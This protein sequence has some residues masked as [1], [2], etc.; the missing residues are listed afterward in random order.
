MMPCTMCL[1]KER[2]PA[3]QLRKARQKMQRDDMQPAGCG[4]EGTEKKRGGGQEDLA[5]RL[6]IGA[7]VNQN[8]DGARGCDRIH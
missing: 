5:V 7:V 6:G 8:E 2:L 1:A 4:G 3:Q